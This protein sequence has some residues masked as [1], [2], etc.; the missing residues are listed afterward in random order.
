METPEGYDASDDDA[1]CAR[2][3]VQLTQ[4]LAHNQVAAMYF[5]KW[6][7]REN[8]SKILHTRYEDADL[9]KIELNLCH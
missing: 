8:V 6:S 9:R 5:R 2:E 4:Q 3:L 1:V 7:R